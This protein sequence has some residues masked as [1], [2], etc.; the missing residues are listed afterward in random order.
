MKLPALVPTISV[1]DI[2][3]CLQTVAP[4]AL[5]LLYRTADEIREASVGKAVHLRGLLEISNHCIRQCKYCGLRASNRSVE[6]Y[7]M[8]EDEIM[9]S[10]SQIVS[11]G[12][13]TVV[14]QAGE[15]YG[16]TTAFMADVI[17]RIKK[18]TS[19]AIT[20]SLGERSND[21]LALWK[22]AG[23]DRY[24]LRFETSNKA[25]Y[26]H[27]HP[28]ARGIESDR[29]A[30]LR[31]LK[32]L[33]YETG[34]GIMVGIPGQ[35]CRMIAE[36]IVLFRDLDMDM[37]GIGPYIAHLDTPLSLEPPVDYNALE[38]TKKV[39]AL[40]RIVRPLANIPATTAFETLDP[41]NGVKTALCL[42]A[43]VIMPNMT[44]T[45]Y[46]ASYDIYPGKA[47]GKQSD[48]RNLNSLPLA[49][50]KIDRTPGKNR[51]DSPNFTTRKQADE[52]L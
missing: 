9:E 46:R 15:E 38:M 35:N 43:N 13:G 8:S 21:E 22:D 31:E 39:I 6:R 25:L 44:L 26:K 33:G 42:G 1:D 45:K 10:V 47:A 5:E 29:I 28:D 3:Q 16:I 48:W 49:L 7:R 4:T 20:L 19:L 40:T 24:L 17:R 12:L 23:A 52:L 14:M 36:D 27:I 51:G 30:I 34:T 18:E 37:I 32:K 41:E 2:E 11:A 50:A